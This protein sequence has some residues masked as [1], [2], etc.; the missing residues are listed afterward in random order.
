MS[1]TSENCPNIAQAEINPLK[2]DWLGI[3]FTNGNQEGQFANDYSIK[4]STIISLIY[5]YDRGN[6]SKYKINGDSITTDI[7]GPEHTYHWLIEDQILTLSSIRNIEDLNSEVKYRFQ[8]TNFDL[9]ILSNLNDH[10]FNRYYLKSN[11][12]EIDYS[13]NMFKN[14]N[15]IEPIYDKPTILEFDST[16][17]SFV[18]FDSIQIGKD[19]FRL[20][21]MTENKI[22]LVKEIPEGMILIHYKISD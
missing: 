1:C 4:D 15:D 5:P 19:I 8:S 18:G 17:D 22:L 20:S 7:F 2:G 6:E 12:W 9:E 14:P 16:T 11:T 3:S 21:L 10:G 13:S